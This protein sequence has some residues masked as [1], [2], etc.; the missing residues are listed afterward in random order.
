MTP[1]IA[2]VRGICSG[3]NLI[4]AQNHDMCST[5]P[6]VS[7]ADIELDI[8]VSLY[9]TSRRGDLR[10]LLPPTSTTIRLH[11]GLRWLSAEILTFTRH[12]SAARILR[13]RRG[14]DVTISPC[15]KYSLISVGAI[16]D[17]GGYLGMS[18]PTIKHNNLSSYGRIPTCKSCRF[19]KSIPPVTTL[20]DTY[21]PKNPWRKGQS[22][23][24]LKNCKHRNTL[25]SS[26]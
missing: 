12:S 11:L 6:G 5:V 1:A 13:L 7:Q 23:G 17:I 4:A 26:L 22:I 2:R 20:H 21:T 14:Y 18:I 8:P 25:L 24:S 16:L 15:S 3:Q 9:S 19:E 10:T